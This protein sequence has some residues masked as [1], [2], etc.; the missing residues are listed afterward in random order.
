MVAAEYHLDSAG[1]NWRYEMYCYLWVVNCICGSLY[2]GYKKDSGMWGVVPIFTLQLL[3]CW[4]LIAS[5]S[6]KLE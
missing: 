4:L 3:S 5:V 2:D 1:M 6:S